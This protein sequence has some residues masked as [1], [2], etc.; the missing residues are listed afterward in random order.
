MEL[1]DL[2]LEN[3]C[4]IVENSLTPP[5]ALTLASASPSTQDILRNCLTSFANDGRNYNIP[6]SFIIKLARLKELPDNYIIKV[7][8]FD[9][10]EFLGKHPSL[11]LAI[12]DTSSIDV[13]NH[14]V[15]LNLAYFY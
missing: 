13:P 10:I 2:P 14:M 3:L 9:E 12:I 7:H 5:E 8:D 11:R 6:A 4:Q 1:L 15:L